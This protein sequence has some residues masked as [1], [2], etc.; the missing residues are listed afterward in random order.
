MAKTVKMQ[1]NHLKPLLLAA[2]LTLVLSACG[3]KGALYQTPKS[4][5]EK[6]IVEQSADNKAPE[7]QIIDKDRE[8]TQQEQQ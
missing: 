8:K 4:T 1:N 6:P 7:T 5:A 2:S 3:S